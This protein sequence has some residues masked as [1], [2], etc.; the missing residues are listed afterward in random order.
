[1]NSPKENDMTNLKETP[2]VEETLEE[3]EKIEAPIQRNG[4]KRRSY[5]LA[6]ITLLKYEHIYWLWVLMMFF[7]FLGVWISFLNSEFSKPFTDGT[8]YCTF[9]T[10]MCPYVLEF[11]VELKVKKKSNVKQK[12]I[13]YKIASV[14]L[15]FFHIFV[16]GLIIDKPIAKIPV[17]QGIYIGLS[18][19]MTLYIYLV[20]KM[21]NHPAFLRE[22]MDGTYAENE[23]DDVNGLIAEASSVTNATVKGRSLDI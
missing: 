7:S 2:S 14:V 3:D 16:S 8:F 23:K 13:Y 22:F 21:D 15:A 10:I 19:L 9:I 18:V 11:F 4:K 1:M 20:F 17:F 6:P 12:F 5:L